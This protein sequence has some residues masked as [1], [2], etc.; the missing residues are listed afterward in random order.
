MTA[1]WRRAPD[2]YDHVVIG[3][4]IA[5][6]ST[7][8]ALAPLGSVLV[9]ERDTALGFHATARSV[10]M[11]QPG[12]G[13]T[14]VRA[15]NDAS[16]D[17]LHFA[18]DGVLRP[19]GQLVLG[20]DH[21][22]DSFTDA[23][24]RDG[25]HDITLGEAQQMFPVLNPATVTQ[26]AYRGDIYDLDAE[27]LI[28]DYSRAAR[29]DGAEIRTNT[30][31]DA[32]QYDAGRWALRAGQETIR[33]KLVINA[34]GAWADLVAAQA[35]VGPLGLAAYRQSLAQVPAPGGAN[36]GTWPSVTAAGDRWYAKP[37]AG[38]L[39]I[40]PGDSDLVDPTAVPG[41]AIDDMVLA[42][43][44]ARYEDMV[45]VPVTQV[46]QAWAGLRSFAPDR[47]PVV[48]F[49][50]DHP[51]F[52]WLAGQGGSGF[53]TAPALSDLA[54]DLVAGRSTALPPSVVRA[55]GPKRLRG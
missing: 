43:G 2:I 22:T 30:P 39:I 36:T 29:D 15:L 46:T 25:L 38:G 1:G 54:A 13:N 33:A 40:S 45:T 19:R 20:R 41:A 21:D 26:A 50:P 23:V 27:R 34:A 55:M 16:A 44:L 18:N 31:I 35:G 52:F 32:M 6:L 8:A 14:T 48:G 11:F 28:Q 3:G 7:A 10:A 17:H 9:L 49:D 12:Y 51:A 53:Q 24:R 4:G 5:G 37:H 42:Q 47:T